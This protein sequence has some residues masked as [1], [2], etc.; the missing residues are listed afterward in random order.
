VQE[1]KEEIQ[2]DPTGYREEAFASVYIRKDRKLKQL[3]R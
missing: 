2:S 1:Y 3:E